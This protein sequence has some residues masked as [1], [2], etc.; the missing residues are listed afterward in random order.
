MVSGFSVQVSGVRG[1][2]NSS[3]VKFAALQFYELFNWVN[4]R[5]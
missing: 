4:I 1:Q 3:P 5:S 2:A